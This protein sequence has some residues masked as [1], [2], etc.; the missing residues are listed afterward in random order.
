[1]S[2]KGSTKVMAGFQIDTDYIAR[3][4]RLHGLAKRLGFERVLYPDKPLREALKPWQYVGV[5]NPSPISHF[6]YF[7]TEK[8]AIVLAS[9]LQCENGYRISIYPAE[10]YPN[11][12]ISDVKISLDELHEVLTNGTLP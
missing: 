1:M 4:R 3:L 5:T 6:Y 2:L 12:K 8:D 9:P 10:E 7:K 11:R